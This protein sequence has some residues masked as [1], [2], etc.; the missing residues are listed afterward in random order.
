MTQTLSR[1]AVIKI[2]PTTQLEMS[3]LFSIYSAFWS[4]FR[5]D[6]LFCPL[7]AFNVARTTSLTVTGQIIYDLI[8]VNEGQGWQANSS[9]FIAPLDGLYVFFYSGGIMAG[10]NYY[11][12]LLINGVAVRRA[13]GGLGFIFSSGTDITSKTSMLAL[14]TGDN[15]SI[16]NSISTPL[17]S[18]SNALQIAFSG[19]CY[20]PTSKQ[21]NYYVGT[22]Y[23]MTYDKI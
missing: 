18:D 8:L 21:K 16:A 2:E 19:F 10:K 4:G 11:V 1:N 9:S 13:A 5:L 17:F 22:L 23:C 20:N 3:T 6:T 15:V 12:D 14:K 7:I